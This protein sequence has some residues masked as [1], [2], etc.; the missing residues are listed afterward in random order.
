MGSFRFVI[1]TLLG[2]ELEC[3]GWPAWCRVIFT[4][5][6]TCS[7]FMQFLMLFSFQEEAISALEKFPTPASR[8]ALTDILEQDQ[9]FYKVRMQ[10]CFCLSKVGV[11]TCVFE[12]EKKRR[13]TIHR[14]RVTSICHAGYL[15]ICTHLA[16]FLA[17]LLQKLQQ[18]L[19]CPAGGEP[20]ISDHSFK[21]VL[22]KIARCSR[23]SGAKML[24]LFFMHLCG[25]LLLSVWQQ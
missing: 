20:S 13:P 23:Y 18:S 24:V 10:A 21:S 3:A 15:F 12:R 5:V 17:T 8:L 4:Y 2:Q 22:R 1:W 9:C 14:F 6:C 16:A 11:R 7:F 25:Y 19:H